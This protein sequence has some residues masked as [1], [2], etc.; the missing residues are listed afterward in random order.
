MKS[1]EFIQ[2]VNE[3]EKAA[4]RSFVAVTKHFLGNHKV[5]DYQALVKELVD[6]FHKIGSCMYL[7]THMLDTH[8]ESFKDNI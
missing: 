5:Q 2:K 7:Q 8:F 1:E 3:E 4:W 6:N